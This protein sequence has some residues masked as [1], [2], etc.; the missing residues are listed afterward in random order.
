MVVGLVKGKVLQLE[1]LLKV[2]VDCQRD[3]RLASSLDGVLFSQLDVIAVLA[4][5]SSFLSFSYRLIFCFSNES[6]AWISSSYDVCQTIR[7]IARF[8]WKIFIRVNHLVK[9]SRFLW[10][11]SGLFKFI[12]QIVFKN[13]I[14]IDDGIRFKSELWAERF[15]VK[16]GQYL[17]GLIK[18][19]DHL[20]IH[21]CH[22]FAQVFLIR[23]SVSSCHLH[24]MNDIDIQPWIFYWLDFDFCFHFAAY[25]IFNV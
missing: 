18:W 13:H 23:N 21:P 9:F 20:S 6:S 24:I 16:I 15:A 8:H 11:K 4:F 25:Q 14:K 3:P 5:V 2:C 10:I 22:L 7:Y 12:F 19:A 17:H 1:N